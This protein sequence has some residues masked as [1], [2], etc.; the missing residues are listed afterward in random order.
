MREIIR[1]D[2]GASLIEVLISILII[3]IASIGTLSYFSSA[4]GNVGR[5]SNRRAALERARQRLEQLMAVSS[6]AIKPID[7]NPHW[8]KCTG[9]P[10]TWAISNAPPVPAETVAVED[11][12]PQALITTVQCQHDVSAGTPNGNCDVLEL[13]ATV[14]FMPGSAID[15]EFNRVQIRTLRTP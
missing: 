9:T 7:S 4:L 5:Q 14:W 3:V 8:L 11:L 2:K 15:D 10:C 6:T 1:E 13:S 12:A